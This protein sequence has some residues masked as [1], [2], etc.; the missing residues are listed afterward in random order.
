[1][2]NIFKYGIL[3]AILGIAVSCD[4]DEPFDRANYVN[5]QPKAASVEVV[6]QETAS[7]DVKI[8]ATTVA[9]SD[10]T[11]NV[12]LS[13]TSSLDPQAFTLPETVTI[14]GGSNEGTLTINIT[15]ANQNGE[16]VTLTAKTIDF[17]LSGSNGAIVSNDMFSVEVVEQCLLNSANLS[18]TFDDYPA[19]T[20]WAIFSAADTSTPL[21]SGGLNGAYE[22]EASANIKFCLEDGDYLLVFFDTYG[23]GF[24]CSYGEG[25]YSLT[26]GAGEVIASGGEFTEQDV[27]PFSF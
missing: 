13:E 20:Y 8:Y 4:D 22:G 21:Y 26:N 15:D 16:L 23:D 14:P 1:M 9:G 5:F 10:R 12:N 19:E 27:K 3:T 11:F 7:V 6:D 25:S 2:K 17:T 24:C 18:I